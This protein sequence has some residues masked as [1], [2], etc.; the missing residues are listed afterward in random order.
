METNLVLILIGVIV[1]CQVLLLVYYFKSVKQS[2]KETTLD[3]KEWDLLHDAQKK[4]QAIVANS[5]LESIRQTASTRLQTE[6]FEKEYEK[7]M[8]LTSREVMD[9]IKAETAKAGQNYKVELA[10]MLEEQKMELN[11][12]KKM[13]NQKMEELVLGLDK[14]LSQTVKSIEDQVQKDLLEYKKMRERQIDQNG[15]EILE[16]AAE[17]FIGKALDRKG[18]MQLIYEALERAKNE[19]QI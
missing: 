2:Q 18:H 3:E 14:D 10:K 6:K 15:E 8:G 9:L 1:V 19:K 5:E 4:S 11:D 12:N 17:L 16:K 13:T 7:E